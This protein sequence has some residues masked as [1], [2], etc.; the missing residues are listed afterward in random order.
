MTKKI[1]IFNGPQGCGKT[2]AMSAVGSH[3]YNRNISSRVMDMSR[4]LKEAAHALVGTKDH[5][6]KFDHGDNR[7]DKDEPHPL[8]FGRTPRDMYIDMNTAVTKLYN[9]AFLVNVMCNVIN[10]TPVDVIMLNCGVHQEAQILVE[11]FGKDNVFVLE[12]ERKGFDF[13]DYREYIGSKLTCKSKR[14]PN[15]ENEKRLF[16]DMCI[17]MVGKYLQKDLGV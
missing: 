12:L 2:V 4:P 17:V 7:K 10:N 8:M 16:Y 11:T 15:F 14:V 6:D 3:L 13:I 5:W 1:I 9:D